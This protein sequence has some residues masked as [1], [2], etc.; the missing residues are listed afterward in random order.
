MNYKAEKYSQ[1]LLRYL[2]MEHGD[3]KGGQKYEDVISLMRTF[4]N[5]AEKHG[6]FVYCALK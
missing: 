6:F 2:Q 3:I 5:I 1:L 4:F